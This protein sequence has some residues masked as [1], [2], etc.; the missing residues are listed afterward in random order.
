MPKLGADKQPEQPVHECTEWP[1]E[2]EAEDHQE[3]DERKEATSA[4]AILE[5]TERQCH[6]RWKDAA[7]E[8]IAVEWWYGQEVEQT[9]EEVY[10]R[11]DGGKLAEVCRADAK[12]VAGYERKG[13]GQDEVCRD[14]GDSDECLAPPLVPEVVRVIGHRLCPAE[15]KGGIRED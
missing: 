1:R 3:Y 6:A 4:D 5:I 8:R 13:D 2:E 12:G 15:E 7:Q 10:E 14:A 9:Q 11:D